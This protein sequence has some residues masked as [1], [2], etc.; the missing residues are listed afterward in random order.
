MNKEGLKIAIFHHFLSGHCKGGG[1]KLILQMKDYLKA[2]LWVGEIELEAWGEDLK[3]AD[4]FNQQLWNGIGSINWL[5]TKSKIPVWKYLKR[6]LN[7][8]LNPKIKELAENYD[9]VI[10]SFGNIAFVPQRLKKINSKIKTLAYIHTPPRGFSDQ[11]EN[12]LAK[13]PTWKR[14]IAKIF[15]NFVILNLKKA[16]SSIDILI[17]NSEN[18]KGRTLKYIGIEPTEVIFPACETG[19]FKYESTGDFYLSHGRLEKMKRIDLIIEAFAQMP[20][21]KLIITSSGPMKDWVEEQIKTRNMT[22]IIYEGRVSDQKRSWLMNNCIAGIYIPVDEDAGITQCEFMAAG[23][24]VIGVNEGGLIETIIPNQ[25]GVLIS[26]NPTV[27]DLIKAVTEMTP[28]VAQQMQLD[29][30]KQAK[31]YD[32]K[33]FFEKL[34]K[35]I[36]KV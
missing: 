32:T 28:Q 30:E 20:D 16:L 12:T 6:Q 25:T 4:P 18:I 22:N 9:L 14:P 7:F 17:A 23:K 36:S 34:D 24:P 5:H 29:C 26:A 3:N 33:I 35:I 31:N 2:D 8:L 15:R 11:F 1:E 13:M 21:K 10:F 19:L 27:E